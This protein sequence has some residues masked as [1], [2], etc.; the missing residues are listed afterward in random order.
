[1]N[2]YHR[3]KIYKIVDNTND[4]VYVGSTC[5]KQLSQRLNDHVR[6]YKDYLNGKFNYV[7]S[8]E[9]LKNANYD[10]ILLETIKCETKDELHARERHYIETLSCVNKKVEG[11]TK[12][13]YYE[14]NK[15][16]IKIYQ[17]EWRIAHKEET[18]AYQ[19]EWNQQ[20]KE[21]Q[22]EKQRAYKEKNKELIKQK[23][24]EYNLRKK[25]LT[26]SSPDNQ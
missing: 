9:I 23:R 17:K 10:I 3:G 22:R 8:F 5:Q 24:R 11:R 15:E 25:Q 1:M 20:H 6:H 2:R 19:K 4:Q 26:P 7:S 21:E 18:K 14:A 13:E 12:K 16:E